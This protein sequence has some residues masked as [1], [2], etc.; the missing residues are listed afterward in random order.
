MADPS[1]DSAEQALERHA[2]RA[3][4]V[5][6][7]VKN[8][9]QL[10]SSIVLLQGRRADGEGARQALKAVQQRVAAVSVAHRHV[11]WNDDSEQ[12][13]V[14]ALVR[15]IVG[16]LAGSAGREGVDIDL[17]LDSVTIPGRQAAPVALLVS[18]AVGNALRHAYPDGREGRIQ[19]AVRRTDPGF[20]LMVCDD[21]IGMATE[22]SRT[23]FGLTVV[24]LMTQQLRGRLD[25]AGAQPGLRLSVSVPMDTATLSA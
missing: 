25:T 1:I 10:I 15:E 6:H 16:D 23:G 22:T 12:V 11:G 13:E 9:L 5:E 3:R 20:D 19:V 8:T 4:E 17:D 21:G 7:R 14:S 2:Q 18:E 24:Q